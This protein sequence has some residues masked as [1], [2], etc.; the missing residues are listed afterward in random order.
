MQTCSFPLSATPFWNSAGNGGEEQGRQ[1]CPFGHV[2]E[3]LQRRL[4]GL[5]RLQSLIAPSA[6]SLLRELPN[7]AV[8]WCCGAARLLVA[9]L[10][11]GSFALF[12]TQAEEKAKNAA[13][14]EARQARYRVSELEA[15][16]EMLRVR[17]PAPTYPLLCHLLSPG[18]LPADCRKV[19]WD[20]KNQ[21]ASWAARDAL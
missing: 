11:P 12:H 10:K 13:V 6:K 4:F 14:E 3:I 1:R 7:G 21:V 16:L 19:L 20:R 15:Q 5:F 18:A 2:G 8:D 17:I 9:L